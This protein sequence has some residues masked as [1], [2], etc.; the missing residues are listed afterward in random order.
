MSN[1][2]DAT[3]AKRLDIIVKQNQTFDAIINLHDLNDAPIDLTGMNFKLSIRDNGCNSD[4]GCNGDTPFSLIYKQDMIPVISGNGQI[5]FNDI[6]ILS[7]GTY[8]YDL[9]AEYPDG[10]QKYFLAGSFKVKKSYTEITTL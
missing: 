4:C 6:I 5:S 3:I 2:L 9:L 7:P 1:Q 10:K 8:K